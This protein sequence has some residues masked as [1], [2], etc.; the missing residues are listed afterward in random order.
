[1]VVIDRFHCI[2]LWYFSLP[3]AGRFTIRTCHCSTSYPSALWSWPM[4]SYILLLCSTQWFLT[5]K[6]V[7]LGGSLYATISCRV[8]H[9]SS[10]LVCHSTCAT[11][12]CL[13][14]GTVYQYGITLVLPWISKH[15]HNKV[16][17]VITYPFLKFNSHTVDVWDWIS[18]FIH[19][20]GHGVTYP[21]CDW[22]WYMLIKWAT[23]RS[24]PAR[25]DFIHMMSILTSCNIAPRYMILGNA[26]GQYGL[27]KTI[28]EKWLN[29]WICR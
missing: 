20:T 28:C 25:E 12:L 23:G 18:N 16:W 7:Q 5:R 3:A 22:S 27:C 6:Y 29:I 15:I 17:D 11:L 21:R 4:P 24:R 9:V 19:F 8:W 14:V 1:M 2:Y 10:Y 13:L 26:Y